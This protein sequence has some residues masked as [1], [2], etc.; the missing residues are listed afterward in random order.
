MHIKIDFIISKYL[1]CSYL[2]HTLNK[3]VVTNILFSNK[4]DSFLFYAG[5]EKNKNKNTDI[6]I[7][8]LCVW[9]EC[10][11]ILELL[12]RIYC[13]T[14]V[15][16]IY[17]NGSNV[18]CFVPKLHFSTTTY[19]FITK[20]SIYVHTCNDT[21]LYSYAHDM[22]PPRQNPFKIKINVNSA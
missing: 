21:I 1:N 7:V 14:Y 6:S 5:Q 19:V 10:Q 16:S 17:T 22:V 2:I 8:C 12:N 18:I 9:I 11:I 15:F 13:N 3:L 20:Q 4:L